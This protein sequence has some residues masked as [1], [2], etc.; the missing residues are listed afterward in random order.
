MF[1]GTVWALNYKRQMRDVN[2]PIAVVAILLLLV[3]TVVSFLL[4]T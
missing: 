2:R 1:I 3:S 4:L